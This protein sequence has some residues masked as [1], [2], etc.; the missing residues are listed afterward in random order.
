MVVARSPRSRALPLAIAAVLALAVAQAGVAGGPSEETSAAVAVPLLSDGLTVGTTLYGSADLAGLSQ[1]GQARIDEAVE[2]GL[3]GFTYYVDWVELEPEPGRYTTGELQATLAGLTERGLAPFVNITVGDIGD[4]NLPPGLTDG[5][6]G[7]AR[8]VSLGDRTVTERFGGLLQRVAPI[9]AAHGGF[10][11]GVGNEV[12]DRLDGEFRA[13]LDDYVRFV[14][15]ARRNVHAVEPDLAVGVT[16]TADAVRSRSRTFRRMREAG[17]VVAVNYA[18][19]R[20]D[21]RVLPV[22]DIVADFRDVLDTYDEGSILIQELSCPS[23]ISMGASEAWQAECFERLFEEIAATPAV[24]FASIF[25][26]E[27]FDER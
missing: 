13:E 24:R 10:F 1:P 16:L 22:D 25:T 14:E 26:F 9:V 2:A 23:A 4:Y 19:I 12:D 20:S 17:D 3:G 21:L 15:E 8:G 18:P 6:G 7:L 5:A 27:D 11:L